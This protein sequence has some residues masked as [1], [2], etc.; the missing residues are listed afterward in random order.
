MLRAFMERDAAYD[1]LFFTGVTTTGIFCKA[2]CTA[3]KPRPDNVRFF[4]SA[5]EAIT[6]GFRECMRCKPLEQ[7]GEPPAWIA[8]LIAESESEPRITE[9]MLRNRGLDPGRVRRWFMQHYGMSFQAYQRSRR[10][11]KAFA[12]MRSGSAQT[13]TAYES[14]YESL[15][16]FRTAYQKTFGTTPA[17]GDD[18][19]IGS[20]RQIDTPLGTMLTICTEEGVRLLEFLER[21]ALETELRE[22]GARLDCTI[23]PGENAVTRQLEAELAEYFEGKRRD[24]EVPLQPIGTPFQQRVWDVLRTIPY[25]TTRSYA[26][27]ARA[28]GQPTATRAV[29][30]ANGDNK[31]AIIIP[32]HRVI[33][34]N[35]KL[36]GYGGGLWR[37]QHLLDLERGQR[38]LIANDQIQL[39]A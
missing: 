29:A 30:R 13:R 17:S 26:E 20:M 16:G 31:I 11:G 36:T 32:C 12:E 7:K 35:G 37:K 38:G 24:F 18:I 2:S 6:A 14:G 23:M 8:S 4:G 21:R 33:G 19:V 27:Q 15:S 9:Q 25:G 10:L 28:I 1:G 3:R 5:Q 39:S 34:A 22:L